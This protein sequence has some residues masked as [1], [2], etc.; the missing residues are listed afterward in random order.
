MKFTVSYKTDFGTISAESNRS[1]DLVDAL[2]RLKELEKSILQRGKIS[3]KREKVSPA[4]R[5][6]KGETAV[7]MKQIESVLIEKNFFSKA[8][9]TGETRDRLLDLTGRAFTSRKVSQA[10]GIL[11]KKKRLRRSGERNFYVYSN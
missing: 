7:V 1:E 6:G 9:T 3:H 4:T 8:R 2:D 10:L 11:W 5:G